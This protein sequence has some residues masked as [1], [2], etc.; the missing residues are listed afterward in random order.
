MFLHVIPI[1]GRD[2]SFE[3]E[4]GFEN[5]VEEFS[6]TL[7]ETTDELCE[8]KFVTEDFSCLTKIE[9]FIVVCETGRR[10][11]E[12]IVEFLFKVL[13][14]LEFAKVLSAR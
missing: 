2:Y 3:N 13:H 4:L 7:T 8:L 11:I 5:V 6:K 9:S 1:F 10:K 14:I 12:R